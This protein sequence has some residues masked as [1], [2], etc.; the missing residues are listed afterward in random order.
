VAAAGTF[1]R[2]I[3]IEQRTET[4]GTDGGEIITWSNYMASEPA[5]FK[6]EAGGEADVTEQTVATIR[7]TF[8]IRT[9]NTSKAI[10][11]A[12]RISFDSMYWNITN[13]NP[14]GRKDYIELKAESQT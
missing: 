6:P 2:R 12:M 9:S 7:G 4:R 3:T 5:M 10:T 11:A 14:Y 1:D 8:T 13:I